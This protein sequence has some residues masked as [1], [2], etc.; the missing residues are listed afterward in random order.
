MSVDRVDDEEKAFRRWKSLP[1]SPE[2]KVLRAGPTPKET[3]ASMS[4]FLMTEIRRAPT[5]P[6]RLSGRIVSIKIKLPPRSS[7]LDR[8]AKT[9]RIEVD[10]EEPSENVL[11]VGLRKVEEH[12][13]TMDSLACMNDGK[14][15]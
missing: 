1:R 8:G 13:G 4:K 14:A 3:V 12:L 11:T 9:G 5:I 7:S 2:E 10:E 6:T 15:A